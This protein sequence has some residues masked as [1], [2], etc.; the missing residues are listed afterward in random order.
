MERA[1]GEKRE[2]RELVGVEVERPIA[3]WSLL[4]LPLLASLLFR[5][6]PLYSKTT[7]AF[8]AGPQG[9]REPTDRPAWSPWDSRPRIRR[10]QFVVEP[11]T[12]FTLSSRLEKK[13]SE[14]LFKSSP[15][16]PSTRPSSP[17]STARRRRPALPYG[18]AAIPQ[19]AAEEAEARAAS[20]APITKRVL[21]E[22]DAR[23][24]SSTSSASSSSSTAGEP[25]QQEQAGGAGGAT[26]WGALLRADAA[27]TRV[28]EAAARS[29]GRGGRAAAP[30]SPPPPEFI[31]LRRS[32][33]AAAVAAAA[34]S[35]SSSSSSPSQPPLEAFDVA[36]AGGT[37]GVLLAASLSSAG[38]RVAVVEAGPLRGRDQEWNIC[39]EEL[40]ALVAA[41]ALSAA[42]AAGAVVGEFNP[43]RCAFGMEVGKPPAASVI[44]T[45]VLNLVSGSALCVCVCV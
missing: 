34:A 15:R 35:S 44:T 1:D 45:D 33:T 41:G 25:R 5:Y 12:L 43:V 26:T 4:S 7:P 3:M 30:P 19:N 38:L 36:V 23:R 8:A 32:E 20:L 14:M 17:S 42:D 9:Q 29:R 10:I 13:K 18:T 27:W 24:R 11:L 6:S 22:I 37:L 16:L 39:R 28:K 31:S 40:E 2:E 21:D